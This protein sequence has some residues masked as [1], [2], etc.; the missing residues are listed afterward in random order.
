M[1][2]ARDQDGDQE[3]DGDNQN[4]IG[5]PPQKFVGDK[6]HKDHQNKTDRRIKNLA[7]QKV[8]R[9]SQTIPGNDRAGA[10]NH[11]NPNPH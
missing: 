8:V 1:S 11:H 2:D 6:H 9:I 5:Q 7:L 3:K 4:G 10:V